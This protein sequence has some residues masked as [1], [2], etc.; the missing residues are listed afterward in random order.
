MTILLGCRAVVV[1][2]AFRLKMAHLQRLES[3]PTYCTDDRGGGVC[4]ALRFFEC[5]GLSESGPRASRTRAETLTPPRAASRG[6]KWSRLP[7]AVDASVSAPERRSRRCSSPG[8]RQT[9]G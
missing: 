6:G 8:G 4:A 3:G 2:G 1:R 7:G 5:H 9:A